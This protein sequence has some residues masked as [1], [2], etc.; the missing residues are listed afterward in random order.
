MLD[1]TRIRKA[2][3]GGTFISAVH[4]FD[5]VDSTNSFARTNAEDNALIIA[6]Y[7]NAGK[8]RHE[9]IWE[10]EKGQNLTF[11]LKKKLELSAHKIPYINFFF[12]YYIY[13]IIKEFLEQNNVSAS[14]LA[15]KWPND[16]LYDNK[17]IC[18]V[19]VES[20]LNKKEFI[21]GIGINLNQR[22]FM[23]IYNAVSLNTI[24][25]CEVNGTS[26]LINLIGRF[27]KNLNKLAFPDNGL[28]TQWRN[29]TNIIGKSVVFN[30]S[31]VQNKFA[32]VIDLHE[33]GGIKLLINGEEQLFYS[34]EIK[35]TLIGN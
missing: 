25:N 3:L 30:S 9:R 28:F 13:E 1:I 27:D 33:D 15:I 31:D 26:F 8:G 17:K 21:I 18:G 23:R 35:I 24:T 34:G 14:L 29:A 12:S 22:M 10:S 2:L 19:L 16:I 32:N 7:Q 20:N 11:T 5:E 6:E 4:Y